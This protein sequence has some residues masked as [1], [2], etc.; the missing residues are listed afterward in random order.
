MYIYGWFMLRFD[1]KQQN[2]IKQLFF[3]NKKKKSTAS[4]Q[5]QPIL[6]SH[7]NDSHH[8]ALKDYWILWILY[9]P[10]GPHSSRTATT[11]PH[12]VV[13]SHPE[14]YPLNF[15]A[16]HA[17]GQP[18]NVLFPI[19]ISQDLALDLLGALSIELSSPPTH[20][21]HEACICP[22][23]NWRKSPESAREASIM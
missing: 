10:G 13:N 17:S 1:R 23:S 3:N 21:G 14:D 19:L 8:N 11:G 12:I 22:A 9:S 6:F 18:H 16:S 7:C 5:L 20:L 2:S 15:Q 4:P